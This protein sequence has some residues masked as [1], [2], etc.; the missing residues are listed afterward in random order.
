VKRLR[1]T[2]IKLDVS[3]VPQEWRYDVHVTKVRGPVTSNWVNGFEADMVLLDRKPRQ[4]FR[5]QL[6]LKT[7][8]ECMANSTIRSLYIPEA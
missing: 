8:K 4:N 5:D 1:A 3:E 6:D 2:L 7:F